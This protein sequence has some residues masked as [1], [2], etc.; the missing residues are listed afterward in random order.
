MSKHLENLTSIAESA[1]VKSGEVACLIEF[2]NE[3]DIEMGVSDDC[4]S[5]I[6]SRTIGAVRVATELLADLLNGLNED[7][8]NGLEH[9]ARQQPQPEA[10]KPA[11]RG[12]K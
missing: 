2:I 3:A 8:A 11:K 5:F 6:N 10:E 12:A 9:Y 7:L 4:P 1:R